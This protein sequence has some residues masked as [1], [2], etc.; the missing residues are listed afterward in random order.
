MG[1]ELSRKALGRR[2]SQTAHQR[3]ISL[4]DDGASVDQYNNEI[5]QV[6]TS[7]I[8]AQWALNLAAKLSGDG[9]PKL[10]GSM[11]NPLELA[12]DPSNNVYI[13]GGNNNV[14][15]RISAATGIFSNVAGNSTNSIQGGF[16]GDKG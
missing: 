2:I 9:L 15:Q 5:R 12:I 10:Q 16:S 7:G 1:I 3:P 8:I 6:N 13:S 11:W 14:V 4:G